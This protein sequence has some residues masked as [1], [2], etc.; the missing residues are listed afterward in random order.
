MVQNPFMTDMLAFTH[1]PDKNPLRSVLSGERGFDVFVH[2]KRGAAFPV[3]KGFPVALGLRYRIQRISVKGLHSSAII[4]LDMDA[5]LLFVF[6][7]DQ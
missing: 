2:V 3:C 1:V 7:F 4:G 5:A 6:G